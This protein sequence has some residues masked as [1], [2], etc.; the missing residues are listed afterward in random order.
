MPLRDVIY[1]LVKPFLGRKKGFT[2]AEVLS[3]AVE[4]AEM[5]SAAADLTQL[6]DEALEQAIR[7]SRAERARIQVLANPD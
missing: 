5:K 2:Q 1:L 7:A 3:S 6:A 4:H